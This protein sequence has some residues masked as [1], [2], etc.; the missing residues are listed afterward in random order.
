MQDGA[1]DLN[2]RST[3]GKSES[4][5]YTWSNINVWVGDKKSNGASAENGSQDV[6]K[7]CFGR[8]K[9]A[10]ESKQILC[11]GTSQC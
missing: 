8:K 2:R 7:G 3:L 11:N 9:Q 4:I 6:E 10:A 5:T 1:P